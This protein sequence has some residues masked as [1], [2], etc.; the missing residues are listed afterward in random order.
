MVAL[1]IALLGTF[2]ARLD[3]GPALVLPRRKAEALLA[4]LALRPGQP[5]ARDK[6][7]ALLWGNAPDER[8]RHSL[9]Q[10]LVTLRHALLRETAASLEEERAAVRVNAAT[11]EVV[12]ALFEQLTA[13]ATPEA[14][15]RAAALYRGDL[16]EGI[17]LQEPPFEDW[18]RTERERLR[19][20]ALEALAKLLAHQTRT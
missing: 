18:L 6:L 11:V 7:A 17:S 2:E 15:E 10:A 9:R 8:A 4:Y 20:L 5:Q 12:V 19:E 13:E 14:L 16:L 1:R 3:C